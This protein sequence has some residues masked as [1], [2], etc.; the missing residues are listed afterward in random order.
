MAKKRITEEQRA[1]IIAHKDDRPRAKVAEALG[2]SVCTVTRI[3]LA[4]GGQPMWKKIQGIEEI[5]RQYYP[6]MG[7]AEIAAKTGI[8]TA[9]ICQWAKKLKIKHTAETAE[10]LKAKKREHMRE[11]ARTCIDKRIKTWKVRRRIDELRIMQGQSQQTAHKFKELS[12][13]AY[14]ARQRLIKSRLYIKS[15]EDPYTLLYDNQTKRPAASSRHSEAHYEKAYH[16]RFKPSE[17]Q[18]LEKAEREPSRKP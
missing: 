10:R 9:T 14:S 15:D 1:Y 16:F 17:A 4:N 12:S 18:R 3:A 11:I 8:K 7:S 2:L 6:T 5:I 13:R